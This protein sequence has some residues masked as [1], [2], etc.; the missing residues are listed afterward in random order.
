MRRENTGGRERQVGRWMRW[1]VKGEKAVGKRDKWEMDRSGRD[2]KEE[3]ERYVRGVKREE[4][5][6]NT[7]WNELTKHTN[8]EMESC[9]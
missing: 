8:K 3:R 4:K 9:K 5:E 6:Q 1:E 2:G 7:D